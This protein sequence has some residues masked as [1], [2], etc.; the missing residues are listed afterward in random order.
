MLPQILGVMR[1]LI[2]AIGGI[3]V[4]HGYLEDSTVEPLVGAFVT[5]ITAAWSVWAKH[6]SSPEAIQVAT[7]VVAQRPPL[8]PISK[9][10]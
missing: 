5:L 4:A 8:E 9:E 7:N 1:A 6:R 3:L 10:D 2:A